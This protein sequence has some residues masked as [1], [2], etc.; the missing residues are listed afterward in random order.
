LLEVPPKGGDSVEIVIAITKL[1]LALV[2]L[3]RALTELIRIIKA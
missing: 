2:A 3:I 1:V